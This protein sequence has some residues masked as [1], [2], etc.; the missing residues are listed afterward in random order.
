M[1]IQGQT[2]TLREMERSDVV[3]KVNWFNDP[4]VNKLLLLNEKL[5]IP[6]SL[7][8]F[9]NSRSDQSRR[10]FVIETIDG[11]PIGNI[12]LVHINDVH[13]TAEIYIVIGR[14]EFWGKGIMLE[15]EG[16]LIEWAFDFLKFEKIWAD[17]MVNN[18]A[19]IITMKK[20]GFKLEAALLKERFVR[21][22]WI[23]IFRFGL[24]KEEF[25]FDSLKKTVRS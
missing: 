25:T 9:E 7:E 18:I 1:K 20:L 23:D 6:K 13:K 21:E 16:L 22:Q 10:D 5:D 14:K 4:E 24:L 12:S 2:I 8:W 11:T 19:S 17:A 15:A 3:N